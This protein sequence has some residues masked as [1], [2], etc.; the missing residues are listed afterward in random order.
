MIM[1]ILGEGQYEVPDEHLNRLNELDAAL[2]SA[3]DAGDETAFATALSA[4]LDAVRSL[5]TPLPDE[6]ITP[7]DLVLP[8]EGTS[9]TQVRQLLSDEGLIPG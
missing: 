6:Q 4:L 3:A 1:R 8:D 9:L 7:S 2:Q 5:G